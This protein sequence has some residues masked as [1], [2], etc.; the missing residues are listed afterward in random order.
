MPAGAIP[1]DGPSAGVAM[2]TA[3]ISL[4]IG[5]PVRADIAMTGEVTLRGRVLPVG[6]I[7]DKVLGA[8]RAGISRVILPSQNMR[9]LRDLPKELRRRMTFIPV[10]HMDEVLDA[11]LAWE[12][13]R[14]PAPHKANLNQ[15]A[16]TT[17]ASAKPAG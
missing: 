9:D 15:A 13:D 2:A 4:A 5:T 7:R 14:K 3:M 12:G 6:G 1:K 17:V 8:L 16:S 10:D 11:A